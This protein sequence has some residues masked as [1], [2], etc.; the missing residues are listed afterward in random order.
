MHLLADAPLSAM[1]MIC[2]HTTVT[3]LQRKRAACF[4]V[5]AIIMHTKAAVSI[6]L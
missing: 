4:L 6:W 5:P 2:K 3:A 1:A